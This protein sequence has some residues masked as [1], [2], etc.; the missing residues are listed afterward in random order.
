MLV[1]R[2][3][4]LNLDSGKLSKNK[5]H[6]QRILDRRLKQTS[7]EPWPDLASGDRRSLVRSVLDCSVFYGL[8]V[9]IAL[10][11]IPYGTVDSWSEAL[12]ECV[13]FYLALLWI[14]QGLIEGSW[15]IGNSRL[16]WPLIALVLLAIFQSVAWWKT[17]VGGDQVWFALSAD[18]FETRVFAFRMAALVL[19]AMLVIRFTSNTKRL[20]ILVHS[21]IAVAVGTALFGIARQAMQHKDGFVLSRLPLEQGFAQFINKNH[22]AFLVEIA[23]GLI[24]GLAFMRRG[25]RDRAVLYLSPLLL[26]GASIILSK[27]R[28][29][30]LAIAVELI[31]AALMFVNLRA[32]GN[33]NR[34]NQKLWSRWAR[35]LLVTIVAVGVLLVIVV[36]GVFWLGGDQLATG[37]ETA[38]AEMAGGEA[39]EMHEGARRRDI[40]RASWLM[41]KAHPIAGAGLGGFWAEVPVYHS[42]SGVST[43]QQAHND[44]L[45]LLASGGLLGA[46]LFVWFAAALVLQARRSVAAAAGFQRAVMLGAIISVVGLGVHSLVD[47]GLHIT[48]NALGFMILLGILSL[49]PLGCAAST[50]EPARR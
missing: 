26:L 20:G 30:L 44:Y 4:G 34:A 41:F 43:P 3:R 47:F 18:P 31:F 1:A 5:Q 2:Y 19:V 38:T 25:R 10:T 27:S 46:A 40:W 12:F 24:V 6:P 49:K 16:L 48:I 14:V 37:V 35:S 42:A 23:L 39:S 13:V 11:A 50:A 7:G 36:A 22:F 45:E 8:V 33:Q 9:L 32:V 29:G 17:S 15:R 21:I 28:G